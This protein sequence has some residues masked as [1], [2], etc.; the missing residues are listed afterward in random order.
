MERLTLT[1]GVL[2]ALAFAACSRP[3]DTGAPYAMA[4]LADAATSTTD[5]DGDRMPDTLPPE[6]QTPLTS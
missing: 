5:T 4:A 1:I 2:I 3:A 6:V